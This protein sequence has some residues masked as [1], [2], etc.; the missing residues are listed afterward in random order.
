MQ[1]PSILKSR[2]FWAAV[3]ALGLVVARNYIPAFLP[4]SDADIT[5]VVITLIGYILGTAIEDGMRARFS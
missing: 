3:I 5:A 1:L 4:F 2:K